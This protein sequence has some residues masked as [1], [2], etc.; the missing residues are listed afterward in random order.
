MAPIT[1]SGVSLTVPEVRTCGSEACLLWERESHSCRFPGILG[2]SLLLQGTRASAEAS[3]HHPQATPHP[4]Q[5]LVRADSLATHPSPPSASLSPPPCKVEPLLSSSLSPHSFKGLK[6]FSPPLSTANVAL[7]PKLAVKPPRRLCFCRTPTRCPHVLL[8][9]PFPSSPTCPLSLWCILSSRRLSAGA[10]ALSCILLGACLHR[11][12]PV[13]SVGVRRPVVRRRP[14][15]GS[16][17]LI[18]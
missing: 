17:Q 12:R 3:L 18:L 10:L 5:R 1:Q 9:L 7:H 8:R 4:G 2:N 13:S 16:V 15:G 11:V 14:L 6:S